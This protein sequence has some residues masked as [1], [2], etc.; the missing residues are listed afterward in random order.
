MHSKRTPT[1]IIVD[2][3]PLNNSICELLIRKVFKSSD[4]KL[5]IWPETALEFISKEYGK[6]DANNPT[7]LFLDID[8]PTLN[9]WDFLNEF[10]NFSDSIQQ[11]FT[12]FIVSSSVNKHDKEK[13]AKY[14]FVSGFISK[15]LTK[16]RLKEIF[17]KARGK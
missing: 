8:M 4:I 15:P 10:K 3:D 1:F 9:G 16:D 6:A 11:Q 13:A 5:F 17:Y 14:K 7:I 2:D 12:I